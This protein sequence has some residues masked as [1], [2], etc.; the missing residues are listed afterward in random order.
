MRRRTVALVRQFPWFCPRGVIRSA[1]K[2]IEK[3]KGLLWWYRKIRGDHFLF[4]Y[5]AAKA[6]CPIPANLPKLALKA[7]REIV[8]LEQPKTSLFY[9]K[10]VTIFS[11]DGTVLTR[12]NKVFDEFSHY[13]SH[14]SVGQRLFRKPFYSLDLNPIHVEQT[15]AL[16]ATPECR[17]Y[18]HW[19]FD[20]LPRLHLLESVRPNIELYAVPL[21]LLPW[22][23]ETLHFLGIKQNQLLLLQPGRRVICRAIFIASLPGSEGCSPPWAL[24]F[25]REKFLL[26][27]NAVILSHSKRLYVK[28]G[29]SSGRPVVN[30]E[31]LIKRLAKLGFDAVDPGSLSFRQQVSLFR[32]ADFVVAAH[33]AAL[34]NLVFSESGT[35]VLELFSQDYLRPDCYYT[36]S[37]LRGLDYRCWV[38]AT[39]PGYS[40]PWGSI[41]PNPDEIE[42]IINNWDEKTHMHS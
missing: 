31:A 42:Q 2:W 8:C 37:H 25:L 26:D 17:N 32:T 14:S 20:L 18:Y 35:K 30:E 39:P 41:V 16:L 33:G 6:I 19:L 4:C 7:F 10:N 24:D 13:W 9:L 27:G 3:R 21:G 29:A 38:D 23:I 28:R 1:E 40:N 5:P 12:C 11:D 22:Q 36:L 15:I 34:S